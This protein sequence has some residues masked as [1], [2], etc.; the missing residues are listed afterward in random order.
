MRSEH[1][2]NTVASG[3]RVLDIAE[4]SQRETFRG[5]L[6]QNKQRQTTYQKCRVALAQNGL[7]KVDRGHWQVPEACREL[8]NDYQKC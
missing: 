8:R 3:A 6:R 1:L 2:R 4:V 7:E 5:H